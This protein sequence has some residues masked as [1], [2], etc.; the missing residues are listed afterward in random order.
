M[1]IESRNDRTT[2]L[3]RPTPSITEL[4][5]KKVQENSI[6]SVVSELERETGRF[7]TEHR[8]E[9]IRNVFNEIDKET[10]EKVTSTPD[11]EEKP[12]EKK[13]DLEKFK[14]TKTYQ[15]VIG[16]L[17]SQTIEIDEVEVSKQTFSATKK[18]KKLSSRAKL[19]ITTGACC[20]VLLVGLVVCNALAIGSIE[21]QTMDM[22]SQ[23]MQQEKELD[24]L[25]GKIEVETNKV[26]DN[27]QQMVSSGA[28]IDTSPK[29]STEIVTSD[30]FFNKLSKFISYLFGR[31]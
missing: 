18:Q 10:V 7:E 19:W 27:M 6:S 12:L 26:P 29:V 30:N 21:R 4:I 1:S 24:S 13:D 22:Q 28:V 11:L 25:N 2:T 8:P 3:E 23:L 5:D 17:E 15:D 31:G 20:A 16:S 14:K 9:R